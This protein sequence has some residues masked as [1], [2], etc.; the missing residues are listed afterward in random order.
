MAGGIKFPC[1]RD[2]LWDLDALASAEDLEISQSPDL[3][4]TGR[5]QLDATRLL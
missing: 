2:P 1:H 4:G 5:H 3:H